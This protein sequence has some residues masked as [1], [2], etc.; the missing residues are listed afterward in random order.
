MGFSWNN[1]EVTN[2]GRVILISDGDP[3][4]VPEEMQRVLVSAEHCEG[5][6]HSRGSYFTFKDDSGTE[7]DTPC[8]RAVVA[9]GFACDAEYRNWGDAFAASNRPQMP[10][11]GRGFV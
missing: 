11:R 2:E 9:A 1:I 5:Y 8:F 7:D 3:G 4:E 10:S 6:T